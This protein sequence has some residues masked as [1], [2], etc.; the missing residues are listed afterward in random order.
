MLSNSWTPFILELYKDFNI[1]EVKAS[2][3]INSKADRR[4]K[5]SEMV[6]MNY[7]P[8]S[9]NRPNWLSS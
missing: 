5:I 6:V 1:F 2:R 8:P 7:Q 9:T 4:G 3:A